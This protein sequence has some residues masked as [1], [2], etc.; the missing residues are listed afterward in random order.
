DGQMYLYWFSYQGD[1]AQAVE[2]SESWI[3]KKHLEYWDECLVWEPE[4]HGEDLS[5]EVSM[6]EPSLSTWIEGQSS[7][8]QE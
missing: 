5:L 4:D 8:P 1:D 3:D 7:S 6:V 2:E